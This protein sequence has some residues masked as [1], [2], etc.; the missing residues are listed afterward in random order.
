VPK[1]PSGARKA[2]ESAVEDTVPTT[3]HSRH[4]QV[5][6]LVRRLKAIPEV[7]GL[8]GSAL[9]G[10]V[11]VWHGRAEAAGATKT[12]FIDTWRDFLDGWERY[13]PKRDGNLASVLASA[14]RPPLWAVV[15]YGSDDPKFIGLVSLCREL[16]KVAGDGAFH[17]AGRAA[18]EVLNIPPR[19]AARHLKT[20]VQDR[21]LELVAEGDYETKRAHEYRYLGRPR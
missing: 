16:Q 3:L 7:A 6:N 13:D 12:K 5:F 11:K 10:V 19:T 4:R 14:K 9:N 21:V 20:L 8:K 15:R 18:A 2:V 1:L 17:L